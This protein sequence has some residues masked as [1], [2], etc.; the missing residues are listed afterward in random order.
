M[1]AQMIADTIVTPTIQGATIFFR[2]WWPAIFVGWW[3]VF[4]LVGLVD[5]NMT[6]LAVPTLITILSLFGVLWTSVHLNAVVNGDAHSITCRDQY[7]DD[8][9]YEDPYVLRE[10]IVE[11]ENGET[12]HIMTFESIVAGQMVWNQWA[13]I[14][15]IVC[16][17]FAAIVVSFFSF[18]GWIF[19][20][21]NI[22]EPGVKRDIIKVAGKHR[23]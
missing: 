12:N 6:W 4:W 7:D 2:T 9:C 20:V 11:S 18:I 17:L 23:A 5:K 3:A 15:L 8:F 13:A 1:D 10:H 19:G 14:I 21:R 22:D 16:G